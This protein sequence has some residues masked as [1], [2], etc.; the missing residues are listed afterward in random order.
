MVMYCPKA[1]L[2]CLGQERG[3]QM[4]AVIQDG[5]VSA[6]DEPRERQ[7]LGAGTRAENPAAR[8]HHPIHTLSSLTQSLKNQEFLRT[9]KVLHL[10]TQGADGMRT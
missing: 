5:E 4:F 9:R 3:Q 6:K 10:F 1:A 2:G 8:P 7:M